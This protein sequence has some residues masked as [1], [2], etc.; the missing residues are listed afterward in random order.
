MNDGEYERRLLIRFLAMHARECNNTGVAVNSVSFA[1]HAYAVGRR[2]AE[3][4]A[5][6]KN[7]RRGYV[8]V[9]GCISFHP[10][11]TPFNKN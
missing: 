7:A 2:H 1:S 4:D 10:S 9:F 5:C 3:A 8:R 6:K 11:T